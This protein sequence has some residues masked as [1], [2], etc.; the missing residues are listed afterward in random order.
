MSA[1]PS[2]SELVSRLPPECHGVL[3]AGPHDD[4][5][6]AT[7]VTDQ[8][9][10][11]EQLRAQEAIWGIDDRYVLAML[12]WYSASTVLVTPSLVGIAAAGCAFSPRLDQLLLH[13]DRSGL[14]LGSHSTVV[15]GADLDRLAGELRAALEVAIESLAALAGI[16]E[17]PLWAI[18]GD[19]VANRLL[20]AGTMA[21]RVTSASVLATELVAAMGGSLPVPR[22]LDIPTGRGDTAIRF[23]RRVS[24]CQLYRVPHQEMCTSCPRRA[25]ADREARLRS[26]VRATE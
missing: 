14:L 4:V 13:R 19:V 18:A 22:F 2:V 7:S 23:V 15:L 25:A 6:P 1:E 3:T 9:W 16:R 26:A 17:R 8:A 20:W 21:G 12:W 10:L 11:A 24:C 5:V